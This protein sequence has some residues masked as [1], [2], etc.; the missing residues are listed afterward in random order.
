MHLKTPRCGDVCVRACACGRVGVSVC[1]MRTACPWLSP[2]RTC[3]RALALSLSGGGW[4]VGAMSA[5]H[6]SCASVGASAGAP[7]NGRRFRDPGPGSR[8]RPG[9]AVVA[10][11]TRG[12]HEVS[13]AETRAGAWRRWGAGFCRVPP[14]GAPAPSPFLAGTFL[15][16]RITLHVWAT[17]ARQPGVGTAKPG[18]DARR[19]EPDKAVLWADPVPSVPEH[20]EGVPPADC[21]GSQPA[22][23]PAGCGAPTEHTWEASIN[24]GAAGPPTSPPDRVTSGG[25]GASSVMDPPRGPSGCHCA[26]GTRCER[27]GGLSPRPA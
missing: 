22:P 13:W 21:A 6:G 26:R 27:N 23:P 8:G 10:L 1:C 17:S 15:L 19:R 12:P 2:P 14:L 7:V 5:E 4:A 11:L 16:P 18:K 25:P 24:W 9:A 3:S 20:L